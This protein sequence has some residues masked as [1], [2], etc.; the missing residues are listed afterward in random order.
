MKIQTSRFGCIEIGQKDVVAFP[1]GILGFN[2]LR[3]FVILDDPSDEIFVWLQ[4]CEQPEVAFPVL[5]PSFFSQGYTVSLAKRDRESLNLDEGSSPHILTVVTIPED[6]SQ[7]TANLKAPVVI[8]V[9]KKLG[10]Q[11]V[12]QDNKLAIR[13]PIFAQLQQCFVQTTAS[14]KPKTKG[15]AVHLPSVDRSVEI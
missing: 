7:M 11:C 14:I 8:N 12:L 13:E 2:H 3:Q 15:L 10:R 9:N 5:E 1:E 6:P 4:S